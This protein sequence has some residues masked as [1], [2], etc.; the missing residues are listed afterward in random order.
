MCAQQAGLWVARRSLVQLTFDVVV[1]SSLIANGLPPP[2]SICIW[3]LV[4]GKCRG[5]AFAVVWNDPI[6]LFTWV[7]CH[8]P[9]I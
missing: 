2:R 6:W 3:Y 7:I 4:S 9:P 1:V 8:C 5:F